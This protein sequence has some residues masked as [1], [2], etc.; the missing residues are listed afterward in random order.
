[1]NTSAGNARPVTDW[2]DLWV[3]ACIATMRGGGYGVIEDGAIAIADGRIAWIGARSDLPDIT[4]LSGLRTHSARGGW[5]TPGLIDCHNH[6]VFGGTRSRDFE[7]R[8]TGATRAEIAA[9]GGGIMKTIALT[10]QQSEDELCYSARR[11]LAAFA[12]EGCTTIEVKSGYGLDL[13]TE[14]KLLRAGQRAGEAEGIDVAL[15][16]GLYAVPPDREDDRDRYLADV[17][18]EMLPALVGEGLASAIDVQVDEF[19]FDKREA[20]RVFRAAQA[21]GLQCRA[22]TDEWSDFDGARFMAGIG[23]RSVDHVEFASDGGLRAMAA[24]GTYAVLL[25]GNSHILQRRDLPPVAAMRSHGVRMAVG[26][27]CNPGPSPTT[28]LLLMMNM[29][30]VIHGLTPEEALLGVSAHAAGVLALDGDRGTLEL[31]KRADFV[32]WEIEELSELAYYLGFNPSQTV[33]AG[34]RVV[35]ERTMS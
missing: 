16:I 31:G 20:L 32:V 14:R 22:H 8:L 19:G 18:E 6:L 35:R 17:C 13:E 21:L 23:G 34:G 7:M 12:A 30:C 2:D 25:P 28:S 26:S 27:N 15:T 5:I 11:R 1:M 33:V 3:D 10:R 4:H 24:A 9:A 29:A